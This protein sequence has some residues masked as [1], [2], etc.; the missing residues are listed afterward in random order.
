MI[1][2][3]HYFELAAAIA[4][5]FFW[6]RTEDSRVKPFMWYLWLTVVVETLGLYAFL[7]LNNYDNPLFVWVK[8]S[9]MCTNTWLYNSY[10]FFGLILIGWFFRNYISNSTSKGIIKIIVVLSSVFSILYFLISGRFFEAYLPYDLVFR[11]FAIFIFA[12]LYFKELLKSDELIVFYKSHMFYICTALMLWNISLTPL[13]MFD[14]FFKASNAEFVNFRVKFL[15]VSNIILYSC[16][17][18][19]FL[20]SLYFKN[21]LVLRKSH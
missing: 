18:T 15:L 20:I 5:T 3:H 1:V 14:G 19:A 9:P 16:Y 7:M 6:I 8:N 21:K 11:T 12:L 17:T 13:F 2:S 4:A 10:D